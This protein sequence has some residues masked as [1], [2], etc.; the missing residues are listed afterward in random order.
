VN[1]KKLLSC[2]PLSEVEKLGNSCIKSVSYV[3]LGKN[4]ARPFLTRVYAFITIILY[5]LFSSHSFII[6]FCFV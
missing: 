2:P 6:Y 5:L 4:V 3:V 1:F